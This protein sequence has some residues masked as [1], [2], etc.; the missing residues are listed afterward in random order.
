[1]MISS[2]S[3]VF[4][5]NNFYKGQ[6]VFELIH[7]RIHPKLYALRSR[8]VVF[9]IFHQP[10]YSCLLGLRHWHWGNQKHMY[11]YHS[12][13]CM[14][15]IWPQQINAKQSFRIVW[16]K[17]NMMTSSNGT[18][19][20]LLAHCEGNPSVTGNFPSQRPLTRNFVV[21]FDLRLNKRL[22]KQSRRR[23]F[24]TPSRSLWRRCN[25]VGS[26]FWPSA[27]IHIY[28]YIYFHSW[29]K[30]KMGYVIL[31]LITNAYVS[32][33]DRLFISEI[34]PQL[35]ENWKEN[36]NMVVRNTLHAGRPYI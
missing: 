19:S 2:L 26:Y 25:E 9:C 28:M 5:F 4:L 35:C 22:S 21:F 27:P 10:I 20:A 23:W 8:C 36:Y 34:E 6:C 32:S 18:F 17:A 1:M 12:L 3:N 24:E 15:W 31:N 30:H 13:G 14:T 11:N 29:L 16:N 7:N 33:E